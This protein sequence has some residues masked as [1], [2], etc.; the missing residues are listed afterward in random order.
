MLLCPLPGA[1]YR[2]PNTEYLRHF[3]V[4]LATHFDSGEGAAWDC[5]AA[6]FL[7]RDLRMTWISLA[8]SLNNGSWIARSFCSFYLTQF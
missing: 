3:L 4:H 1:G 7:D 5:C 6:S 2:A 8:K